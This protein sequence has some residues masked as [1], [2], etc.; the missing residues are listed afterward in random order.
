[1]TTQRICINSRS[2]PAFVHPHHFRR[3]PVLAKKTNFA[4]SPILCLPDDQVG[5]TQL[6]C[7]PKDFLTDTKKHRFGKKWTA[8]EQIDKNTLNYSQFCDIVE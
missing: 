6:N 2:F 7:I 5:K 3:T 4:F 1:M 8:P